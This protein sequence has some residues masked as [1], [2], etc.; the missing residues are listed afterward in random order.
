[1]VQ[2]KHSFRLLLIVLLAFLLGAITT[3]L[4]SYFV[5]R[6][7]ASSPTISQEL[8][9][10][11]SGTLVTE[12]P[13]PTPTS[14]SGCIPWQIMTSP[15]P[16]E[17]DNALSD[18]ALIAPNDVWAVG[19]YLNSNYEAQTLT[20]HWDGAQWS[21]VPSP[22]PTQRSYLIGVA[23]VASNDVWAV[24][25]YQPPSSSEQTLTLHWDG[26]EWSIIPSPNP[27]LGGNELYDVTALPTG[28]VWA[29][30]KY[31]NSTGIVVTLIIHWNGAQWVII[32]SPSPGDGISELR[33]ISA[34]SAN[35]IW[36][37][38]TYTIS[39]IYHSLML[40]WD[41]TQ[42]SMSDGRSWK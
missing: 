12:T 22:S 31:P 11:A 16:S 28:D 10:A 38:G 36:A 37:V 25:F 14:T 7:E 17:Y 1:M 5:V 33:S 6:A 40:H 3:W 23:A 35:D 20:L 34:I 27:Q 32:P 41:G 15:N 42:W 13:T 9:R 29:V 30:G 26:I 8:R 2:F 18:I 19:H 21:H 24:G 4:L 39:T